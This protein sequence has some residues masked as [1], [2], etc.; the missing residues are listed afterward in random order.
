MRAQFSEFTFGFSLVSELANTLEC[1]AAPIFPSLI[2]EG[3]PGGGYD[4][5]MD[6]AAVPFFLQF[7]LSEHLK[8]NAAKEAKH[9]SGLISAPYRRFHITSPMKSN[10]HASLL[11]LASTAE[12][13][14]YCAPDFYRTDD[15]NYLWGSGGVAHGSVFVRPEDIGPILDDERHAVCFNGTTLSNGECIL[16]SKPKALTPSSIPKVSDSVHASLA[17]TKLPLRTLIG[18]WEEDFEEARQ[19][20]RSVQDEQETTIQQLLEER[21]RGALEDQAIDQ[22]DRQLTVRVQTF[23]EDPEPMALRTRVPVPSEVEADPMTRRL[24]ELSRRAATE[25]GSQ[26]FVLQPQSS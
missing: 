5:V 9:P 23:Y 3:Q 20:A 26:M 6:L 19:V 17:E 2:E 15:L 24:H 4:V 7:K 12:H 14:Y 10:Q 11:G 25:F 21:R 8:T 22:A 13:V 16:F 1:R 18:R